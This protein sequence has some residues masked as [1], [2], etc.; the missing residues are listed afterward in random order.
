MRARA[1]TIISVSIKSLK[2]Q[3]ERSNG[4]LRERFQVLS[5]GSEI[6]IGTA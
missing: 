1:V 3:I 2:P 5:I 6:G 4:P